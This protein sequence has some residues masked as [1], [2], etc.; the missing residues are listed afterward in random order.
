MGVTD[1]RIPSCI[2]EGGNEFSSSS[3]TLFDFVVS[4]F[5]V[6]DVLGHTNEGG[7][8]AAGIRW[9][10][11]QGAMKRNATEVTVPQFRFHRPIGV[12]W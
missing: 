4:I 10:V 11:L 5:L 3:L 1:K 7:L 8:D 12:V 2:V 9:E 6:F